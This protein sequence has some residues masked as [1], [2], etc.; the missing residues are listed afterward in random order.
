MEQDN[1]IKARSKLVY[2]ETCEEFVT[3]G[4]R[5]AEEA[6]PDDTGL[7]VDECCK[8]LEQNLKRT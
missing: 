7:F 1:I 6:F 3:A 2:S 5:I 8:K 4:V